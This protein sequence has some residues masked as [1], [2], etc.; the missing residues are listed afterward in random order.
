M[1]EPK[2]KATGK[3]V[4]AFLATVKDPARRADC[5]TL[6]KLMKKITKQEPTMWG[7]S[8]VGFGT[9]H[10]VYASGREGDWPIVSFSPRKTNL[11]LYIT[12]DLDPYKP[13]L[14][15]LG[16]HKTAKSCLYVNRLDDLHLP[17]LEKLIT[18]ALADSKKRHSSS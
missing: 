1:A 13:M 5:E 10:Y 3:S 6:V 12:N 16:K 4:Q 15:K 18:R 7:S 2:T 11:T 8:I 9:Y 17:T 14:E